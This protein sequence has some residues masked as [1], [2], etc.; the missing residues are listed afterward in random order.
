MRNAWNANSGTPGAT[1]HE[2]KAVPQEDDDGPIQKPPG[3]GSMY[4]RPGKAPHEG[5][6]PVPH[7]G[8]FLLLL[9]R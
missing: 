4:G 1:R 5:G 3:Q 6:C 9:W 7:H 8:A 2:R